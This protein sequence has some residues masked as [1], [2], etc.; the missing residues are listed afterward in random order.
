MPLDGISWVIIAPDN[1]RRKKAIQCSIDTVGQLMHNCSS[2]K[3]PYYLEKSYNSSKDYAYYSTRNQYPVLDVMKQYFQENAISLRRPFWNA[4]RHR[5]WGGENW[6]DCYSEHLSDVKISFEELKK[7][8]RKD[9]DKVKLLGKL[10]R[11]IHRKKTSPFER[12]KRLAQ[13]RDDKL[14]K[15]LDFKSFDDFCKQRIKLNHAHIYRLIFHY[16]LNARL[17]NEKLK[18]LSE[19]QSRQLRTFGLEEAVR[20][21]VKYR[22]TPKIELEDILTELNESNC[23]QPVIRIGKRTLFLGDENLWHQEIVKFAGGNIKTAVAVCERLQG[24]IEAKVTVA[25]IRDVFKEH[26]AKLTQSTLN[27][28]IE[29]DDSF[30]RNLWDQQ[31]G[32][33]KPV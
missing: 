33:S 4:K 16:Q 18:K 10:L 7:T 22:R 1:R 27:I 11:V 15:A 19:Q 23:S 3:I 17:L 30:I 20:I 2:R 13:I 28:G 8:C 12:G 25:I 32:Q 9:Y 31:T 21:A 14:Y 29:I 5:K 26:C 24:V 6:R